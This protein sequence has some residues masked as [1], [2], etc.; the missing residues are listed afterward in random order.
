MSSP[1]C[2]SSAARKVSCMSSSRTATSNTDAPVL[3]GGA[4]AIRFSEAIA[5]DALSMMRLMIISWASFGSAAL[6][7]ATPATFH[8]SWSSRFR[9]V[10]DR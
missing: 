6:S 3:F 7:A 8:A 4:S 9:V 1:G 10:V 2:E 5:T